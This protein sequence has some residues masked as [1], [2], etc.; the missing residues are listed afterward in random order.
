VLE[1]VYRY[2]YR[3]YEYIVRIDQKAGALFRTRMLKSRRR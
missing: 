1:L 3:G 2:I